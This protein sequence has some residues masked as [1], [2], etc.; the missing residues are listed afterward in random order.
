MVLIECPKQGVVLFLGFGKV[1][2]TLKI[3]KKYYGAQCIFGI[4]NNIDPWRLII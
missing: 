3:S 4:P 1:C 2:N